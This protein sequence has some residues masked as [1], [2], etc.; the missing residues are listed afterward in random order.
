M[1]LGSRQLTE[2]SSCIPVLFTASSYLGDGRAYDR[3][4]IELPS[5]FRRAACVPAR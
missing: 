3:G 4:F 5:C 1:V 2:V